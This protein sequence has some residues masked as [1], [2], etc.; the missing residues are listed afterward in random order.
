MT[1]KQQNPRFRWSPEAEKILEA[2]FG[3]GQPQTATRIQECWDALQKAGIS[4]TVM[5]VSGWAARA[6]KSRKRQHSTTPPAS[7]NEDP[8]QCFSSGNSDGDSSESE[9]N[10]SSS[11]SEEETSAKPS[12]KATSSEYSWTYFE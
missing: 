12:S 2:S 6:R 10:A 7:E 4:C 9:D 8:L 1:K 5:Q 3:S 11:E